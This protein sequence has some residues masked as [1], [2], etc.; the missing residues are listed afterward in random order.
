MPTPLTCT[1]RKLSRKMAPSQTAGLLGIHEQPAYG[2]ETDG[3]GGEL[4]RWHGLANAGERWLASGGGVLRWAGG[5][6]VLARLD[7]CCAGQRAGRAGQGVQQGAPGAEVGI[8]R[9]HPLARDERERGGGGRPAV[10]VQPH[11]QR[12]AQRAPGQADLDLA[13][14]QARVVASRAAQL[15]VA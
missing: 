13:G 3:S 2:H 5:W 10:D 14:A 9:P 15:A 7:G 11:A 8:A 4:S 6:Y 12:P 1:A